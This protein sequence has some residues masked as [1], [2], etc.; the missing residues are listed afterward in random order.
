MP[1]GS[2]GT[3]GEALADLW[4][5]RGRPGGARSS[6][7]AKGWHAQFSQLSRTKAGYAAME[8]AGLSATVATQRGWLAQ[9][10]APTARNRG[11]IA[12]AYAAMQGG[13]DPSWR[14]AEYKITGRVT[15]GRDSRVRGQGGNAPFLVDG[16]DGIWTAIE[17][18]WNAGAGPEELERLFVDDV[19][20]N[21]VDGISDSI[22]F[23]G[24]SYSVS[25]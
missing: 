10:T 3:L 11:L 22:E 17:A 20:L 23:E 1:S 16:R 7:Q 13:F 9:T 5:S 15:M 25:T 12:Q 18:A 19:V 2:G 8:Q 6:Y 14:T 24:S 4:S 21:A